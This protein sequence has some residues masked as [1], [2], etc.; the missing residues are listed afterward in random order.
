MTK[1]IRVVIA[2]TCSAIVFGIGSAS[3][4]WSY[5]NRDRAT[6]WCATGAYEHT[7]L[8]HWLIALSRDDAVEPPVDRRDNLKSC[9]L[10]SVATVA[11][12]LIAIRVG[13]KRVSPDELSDYADGPTGVVLDGRLK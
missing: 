9:G 2:L 5:L 3:P 10:L 4:N 1:S 13:A 7:S 11:V 8:W 6:S 12:G